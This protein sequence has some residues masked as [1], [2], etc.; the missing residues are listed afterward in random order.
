MPLLYSSAKVLVYTTLY[1]GFGLPILEAM[2]SGTPVVTSNISS[3]P[4]VGGKAVL[5]AD[6]ENSKDIGNKLFDLMM[7]D[8]FWNMMS[9]KGLEQ[10]KKFSW[11][12]CARETVE[13][14]KRVLD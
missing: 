4:E 2:A 6:P 13:V 11:E 5:Y 7:N 12:N 9:K 8:S 14:Y 10:A 3:L 1:E